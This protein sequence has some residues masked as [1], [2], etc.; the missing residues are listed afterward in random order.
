MNKVIY[1]V[2]SLIF[3]FALIMS[4]CSNSTQSNTTLTTVTNLDLSAMVTAP[5]KNTSP[6]TTAINNAQYTGT[7]VWQNETGS[8]VSGNFAASTVY[9]AVVTL[10]AK[11]GFT[12][13][14]IAANC[15]IYTG[16]DSVTNA[17]GSGIVTI[18]FHPTTAEGFDEIVNSFNLTSFVVPPQTGA[19]P[20]TAAIDHQQ[21]TGT[22][23]WQTG[24]GGTVSG[25]FAASTVY[26]A[27][28]TLSAKPGFT[29]TGI[30]ENC[31]IHTGAASLSNAVGSGIVTVTFAAT[32]SSQPAGN[33][34]VR[35]ACGVIRVVR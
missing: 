31:F 34:G 6:V 15:F 10:A 3:V 30:A 4:G 14:G 25:N 11:P 18:T 24:A 21:Y 16:A 28:V 12:F 2:M 17:A 29:F 32:D 7:V 19:T 1:M 23:V 13:T 27:I 20:D 9:K 8:E 26:K 35:I 33:A 5:V 22:I